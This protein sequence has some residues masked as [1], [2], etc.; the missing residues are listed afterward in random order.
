MDNRIRQSCR[1][2]GAQGAVEW[3]E[4]ENYRRIPKVAATVTFRFIRHWGA[5]LSRDRNF[6]VVKYVNVLWEYCSLPL[7]WIYIYNICLF[8]LSRNFDSFI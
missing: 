4:I 1:G 6:W 8:S 2:D 7:K 5:L 3:N